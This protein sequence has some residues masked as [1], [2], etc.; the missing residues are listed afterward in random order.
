M[1]FLLNLDGSQKHS[2]YDADLLDRFEQF[3]RISQNRYNYGDCLNHK[4]CSKRSA[5]IVISGGIQF[6]PIIWVI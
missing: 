5:A 4:Y 2:N 1:I 6:L 3:Y